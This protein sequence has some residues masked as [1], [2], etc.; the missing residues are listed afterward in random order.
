MSDLSDEQKRQ[1]KNCYEV[2]RN[3]EENQKTNPNKNKF[4]KKQIVKRENIYSNPS[5][6]SRP[7]RNGHQR[8]MSGTRKD[9][10]HSSTNFGKK[11][12]NK[13]EENKVKR[14]VSSML[15][16]IKNLTTEERSRAGG[17]LDVLE[18]E[19]NKEHNRGH[20]RGRGR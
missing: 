19:Q 13:K 8:P 11:Q 1:L 17:M 2:I 12:Q 20:N 16:D 5:S 14:T 10:I 3:Y 9:D 6:S 18:Q 15:G 7:V 4:E